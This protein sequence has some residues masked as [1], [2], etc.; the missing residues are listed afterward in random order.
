MEKFKRILKRISK[1]LFN[2]IIYVA[3]AVSVQVAWF[4]VQFYRL[5]SYSG[6]MNFAVS[7]LAIIVVAL[8]IN[9]EMNSSYKLLWTFLILGIPVFGL[10]AYLLVGES[11]MISRTSRQYRHAVEASRE[12]TLEEEEPRRALERLD[13]VADR[14]SRYIYHMSKAPLWQHTTAEYF[15]IGDDMFPVL[16]KELEAASHF[17]F[18]EYF[19][20]NDGLMWQT[21]LDI[22]ERKASEGVDVRLIYDDFGCMTTLPVRYYEKLRAKRIK[23]EVFNPFRLIANIVHN[24]RD[25][26]KFCIIDGYVGFTGGINLSDE[27]INKKC[28]FGRWKDTAIVL[29]GDAVWNM[30]LMFLQMWSTVTEAKIS[31]DLDYAL[32]KPHVYHP[33]PFEGEGFIQPFGD[34]PLDNELVGENVY[35]SILSQAEHYVYIC[36]PYLIV[37]DEMMSALCVAANSGIDVRI[38]TPG[39]PDKKLVFLL[40]QSYYTRLLRAGVKIYAYQPGFLH[41]KSF[42]CDDKIAVCGTINLDYRSL[43]LH[44]EDGVWIYQDPV[45]KDIKKDFLNTLAQSKKVTLEFCEGRNILIRGMQ[46]V[47]RLVAPLL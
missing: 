31:E 36:T 25:H 1:L 7:V 3:I 46:S 26:R 14:Q 4:V 22:L 17:I 27:Y 12:Y 30:T 10:V 18:I 28:R 13:R 29:R 33:E 39:I 45:I 42:V 47:M 24:N 23:C 43:F 44:F 38:I 37:D 20:I 35:T 16:V 5:T 34:S 19:I 8:I 9:R 2:R 6:Y 15:Q 11:R 40:T 41:A 21:I 32:Y